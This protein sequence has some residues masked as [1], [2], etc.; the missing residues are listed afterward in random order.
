MHLKLFT[1]TCCLSLFFL[2]FDSFAQIRQNT[3]GGSGDE[4]INAIV[5]SPDG[6]YVLCGHTSSSGAGQADVLVLEIDA[7][8]SVLWAYTYGGINDDMGFDMTPTNDGGYMVVGSSKSV[9]PFNE[10]IYALKL[11]GD[12]T[13][14]WQ[15]FI[16]NNNSTEKAFAVIQVSLN[17]YLIGGSLQNGSNPPNAW[18]GKLRWNGQSLPVSKAFGNVG[19]EAINDLQLRS[20]G[21]VVATGV[22]SSFTADNENMLLLEIDETNNST[23]NRVLS[24]GGSGQDFSLRHVLTSDGGYLLYGLSLSCGSLTLN[25]T[26]VK[27]DNTGSLSWAKTFGAAQDDGILDAIELGDGTYAF[28]SFS[29]D[30][31]D[32]DIQLLHT[33]PQGNVLGATLYGGEG[34][35]WVMNPESPKKMIAQGT[36]IVTVA[37]TNSFDVSGQDFY[38]LQTDVENPDDCNSEAVNISSDICAFNV[39]TITD[40]S[41]SNV[42]LPVFPDVLIDPVP[43]DLSP[44]PA[45]CELEA[46]APQT[47]YN[48][49][50]GNSVALAVTDLMSTGTIQYN[51]SPTTDLNDPTVSMPQAS[52]TSNTDYFVT[53]TDDTGCTATASMQV[54]VFPVPMIELGEPISECEGIAITLSVN[55]VFDS[56]T[57]QDNSDAPTFSPTTSGTYALTVTDANGCT[58]TDNIEVSF[59][60]MVNPTI[61]LGGDTLIICESE[62]GILDAGEG[63]VSYLWSDGS[64]ESRLEV[65][66]AG[67]YEVAVTTNCGSG[68]GSI[69]VTLE[70]CEEPEPIPSNQQRVI[71]PTAFSP[72][73][74]GFNDRIILF[75]NQGV[76]LIE[77]AIYNRSGEPVFQTSDPTASWD[78]TFKNDQQNIGVYS[79]YLRAIDRDN[80]DKQLLVRGNITLIR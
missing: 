36:N 67:T 47:S 45:C 76:E 7:A 46:E 56:Y 21:I 31:S 72:N 55:G 44:K 16:G 52:P 66:E 78:G 2:Q 73:N 12:G 57:W 4:T 18:I 37:T 41:F 17:G 54:V 51:W 75:L 28:G 79:Y 34:N 23:L 5:P 43:A 62:T 69:V 53:V 8:G 33:T 68:T 14:D 39:T 64:E 63:F 24:I 70:D 60:S 13:I 11:E 77:F 6:G 38:I 10:Q 25:E 42:P 40:A 80:R 20:D 3:Y 58:A 1:I 61:D 49:C 19:I 30:G 26:A 9:T 74:D 22:E 48:V 50:E 71:V 59:E 29:R 32:I 65:N 35:D 15:K 27:L